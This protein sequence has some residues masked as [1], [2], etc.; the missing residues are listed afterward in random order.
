MNRIDQQITEAVCAQTQGNVYPQA[1]QDI[2][3][4]IVFE[5]TIIATPNSIPLDRCNETDFK[6]RFTRKTPHPAELFQENSKLTPVS[7]ITVPPDNRALEDTRRWYF[8]TAYAMK[9]EDVNQ[10]E[11]WR[12]RVAIDE[13]PN[14]LS[15]LV[16]PFSKPGRLTNLLYSLDLVLLEDK[17]LFKVVPESEHLYLDRRITT[18]DLQVLRASL[19]G[20]CFGKLADCNTFLFIVPCPWRLM[21]FYG[22]RGYRHTLVDAGRLLAYFEQDARR[23]DSQLSVCQDFYD[24]RVDRIL[25]M[26]GVERSTLAIIGVRGEK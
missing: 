11:S 26:D 3:D 1:A 25:H 23:D 24:A 12:F 10:E 18:S 21:V 17:R 2:G 7:T 4:K 16:K 19:L 22:A 8:S 6:F 15:A 9:K 13:L 20:S 14:W 5:E